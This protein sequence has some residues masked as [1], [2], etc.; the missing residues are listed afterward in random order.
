MAPM[1][2]LCQTTYNWMV[3]T[4]IEPATQRLCIM[5]YYLIVIIKLPK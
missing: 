4:P 1:A 5:P 2:G 3:G